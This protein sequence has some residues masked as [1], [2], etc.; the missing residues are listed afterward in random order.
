MIMLCIMWPNSI[1][2]EEEVSVGEIR[3]DKKC[4]DTL[5]NQHLGTVV[6]YHCH[7]SGGNQVTKMSNDILILVIY[8]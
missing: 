8:L 2:K 5:G 3:Q 4:L 7:G 1:P 6:M